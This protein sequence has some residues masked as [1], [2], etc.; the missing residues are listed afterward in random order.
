[1]RTLV[2]VFKHHLSVQTC[3]ETTPHEENEEVTRVATFVDVQS[4]GSSVKTF[5]VRVDSVDEQF[6]GLLD[7]ADGEDAEE[8]DKQGVFLSHLF[9]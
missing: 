9:N 5:G 8:E 2:A 7:A 4:R 6:V 1:M 3:A